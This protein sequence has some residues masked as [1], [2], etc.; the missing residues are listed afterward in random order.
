MR[1]LDL[2]LA[3]AS[4]P[5]L[6][7]TGYLGFLAVMS[8]RLPV[9][10]YGTARR[11]FA[12]LVPAHNEEA[13]IGRTLQSL[14]SLDYPKDQ[15]E[16]IVVADNCS[17]RTALVSAEQG[18][19]VLVRTDSERRGKG[20]ALEFGT[21]H[22]LLEP[23][24]DAIVVIDADTVVSPNL[25]CAFDARLEEGAQAVQADYGVLNATTSWRTRLMRI[26]L[27][28]FHVLRS[29]ARERLGLSCG[30]RGNGMC[31]SRLALER[32]PHRAHSLIEDLEYGL[33]LGE[34]GYRVHYAAEAHV[35]GE[36]VPSERASRTQRLRWEGGRWAMA[37]SHG[38]PLLQEALSTKNWI[39]LD[40]VLDLLVAPLSFLFV[41]A[42]IG[43]TAAGILALTS[44]HVD[45][46]LW[47][48][49]TAMG[50]I[51]I[52]VLRG[53]ALSQ[54]GAKGLI[55]L[56]LSPVYIGWRLILSLASHHQHEW[57]RTTRESELS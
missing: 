40:L 32:V 37:K 49:A 41:A 12:I 36:M 9:P 8:R 47:P 43:T 27:S 31:F 52:Y 10:R 44:G 21:E 20:Y 15:F 26:A 54:T 30:L 45:L 56:S 46:S 13:G 23:G 7:A 29:T 16:I 18:A 22:L 38:L 11:R 53:W 2:L 14:Q 57:I 24:W 42:A 55:D 6:A 34:H 4:L 17:D 1:V 33:R 35:W 25:L 28:M 51:A 19:S 48:W 50:L 5:V 39:L 3:V